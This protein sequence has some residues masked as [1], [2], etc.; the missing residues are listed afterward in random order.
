MTY[1]H[2]RHE[3]VICEHER[4]TFPGDISSGI[5]M[6]SRNMDFTSDDGLI[7]QKREEKRNRR[8]ENLNSTLKFFLPP[9]CMVDLATRRT[10]RVR[11]D[12]TENPHVNYCAKGIESVLHKLVKITKV[13]KFTKC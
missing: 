8:E 4:A 11:V 10:G 6:G 13:S 3:K 2:F 9:R 7:K 5:H 1:L 12:I